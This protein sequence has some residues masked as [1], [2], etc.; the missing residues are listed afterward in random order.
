MQTSLETTA[1]N[2]FQVWLCIPTT[3]ALVISH[4]DYSPTFCLSRCFWCYP[5]RIYR[6]YSNL[7]TSQKCKSDHVTSLLCFHLFQGSHIYS[8]ASQAFLFSCLHSIHQHNTCPYVLQYCTW[9]FSTYLGMLPLGEQC[10][11]NGEG[12][13]LCN[14]KNTFSPPPLFLSVPFSPFWYVLAH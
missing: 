5:P 7:V 9:W 13:N 6:L 3:K 4:L 11:N 10:K 12:L 2:V 8:I 1:F 14:F